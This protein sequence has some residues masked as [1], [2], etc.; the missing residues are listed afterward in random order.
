MK[1]VKLEC[2]FILDDNDD[3]QK[4]LNKLEF[5]ITS[6]DTASGEIVMI[7]KNANVGIGFILK[8]ILSKWDNTTNIISLTT[9][10]WNSLKEKIQNNA[11]IFTVNNK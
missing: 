5:S 11:N 2:Y 7:S 6:T 8:Q 3:N 1:K 4:L 10:Q 9:T